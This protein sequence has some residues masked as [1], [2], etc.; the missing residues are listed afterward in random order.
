M[1]S[2]SKIILLFHSDLP[3][4][5]FYFMFSL[6]LIYSKNKCFKL[7]LVVCIDILTCNIEASI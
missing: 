7:S 5:Y 2:D 6:I 1:F 3:N 4:N